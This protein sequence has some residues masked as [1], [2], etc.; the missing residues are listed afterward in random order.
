MPEMVLE[1][2]FKIVLFTVV[3]II[4]IGIIW[5][6]R[7]QIMDICLFPPCEEVKEC[8]IETVVSNENSFNKDILTRY[9]QLCWEKNKRGECR[10][11]SICY[12]VNVNTSS[13]PSSYTL[14]PDVA[15][16]CSITCSKNVTSVYVQY[17]FLDK[18]V[19]IAC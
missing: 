18:R 9:C 1:Y 12:V 7:K 11:D 17:N 10:K 8:E 2:P 4:L 19:T 6:F 15:Q 13:N 5:T 16:Y 14:Y 3:I